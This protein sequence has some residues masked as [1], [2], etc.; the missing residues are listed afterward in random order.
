MVIVHLV[1]AREEGRLPP[2]RVARRVPAAPRAAE[3][4]YLRVGLARG[5]GGEAERRCHLQI[6]GVYTFPDYLGGR[7]C[8]DF[9]QS[10]LAPIDLSAVPF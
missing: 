1:R 4:V 8:A 3:Q 10:A 5:W 9:P 6:N 2:A 7:C